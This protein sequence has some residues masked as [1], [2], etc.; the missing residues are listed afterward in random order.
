MTKY[1]PPYNNSS[2]NIKVELDLSNYV[3]KKDI[4]DIT[5]VDTSSYP[6]KT[7]LSSLKT[8][9]DNIDT[10]KLKTVPNDLAKLSNVVKN[11]VVKKTEYNTLK[12]KV[13]AINISGFV[14]R[15]KFTTDTNALDDKI[16]KFEKKIPDISGLAT[17]SSLT[18]LINEQED[19]TDRVKKKIP[20]ISGLATK[21]ALTAVENKI[22]D[23]NRLATKTALTSVENKIP[24]VTDLITKTDFDAKLRDISD[25]VTKNKSKDLLLDN[26]LKKLKTFNAD[27]FEGKNYFEGGDGT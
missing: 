25:T 19:Y 20:D 4:K 23:V 10:D 2:E 18:C 16:D 27:Y 17:K 7:N 24:N 26:E 12:N 3:T 14:T 15:T 8:E 9:V 5:Y 22:P 11:D 6:L 13:D 1:F 21:S